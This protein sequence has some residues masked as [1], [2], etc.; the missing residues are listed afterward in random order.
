MKVPEEREMDAVELDDVSTKTAV[1]N[2]DGANTVNLTAVAEEPL[3]G[4]LGDDVAERQSSAMKEPAKLRHKR[5]KSTS[6]VHATSFGS[7]P[8]LETVEIEEGDVVLPDKH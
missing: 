2:E 1:F 3:G 7:V 8:D 6:L 5:S 4:E